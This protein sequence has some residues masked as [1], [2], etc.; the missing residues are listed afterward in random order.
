MRILE[1][2]S[3]EAMVA[4]F[5]QAEIQSPRYQERILSRLRADGKGRGVV[6]TPDLSN[7][8][9]NTYR[10]SLLDYRGLNSR[11]FLFQGFP[12]DVQW[13]KALLTKADF[14]TIKYLNITPWPESSDGTRLVR[15]GADNLNTGKMPREL[16]ADI[17]AIVRRLDAG[18]RL[19]DIILAGASLKDLVIVEGH[20]RS[21]AFLLSGTSEINAIVGQSPSIRNW[22]LY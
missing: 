16:A 13:H 18:Q 14:E 3:E 11:N 21:T 4:A 1:S 5:L 22:A 8:S 6:D 15:C 10:S 12:R 20:A 17:S 2:T 19:P 9:A 7:S